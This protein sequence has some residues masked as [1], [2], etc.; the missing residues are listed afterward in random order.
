MT[1]RQPSAIGPGS[2]E[3]IAM[4]VHE[5]RT[6]L[7]ALHG[8]LAGSVADAGP[9]VRRFAAI[10]DRNASQLVTALDD[11][12]ELLRLDDT[13]LALQRDLADA[14]DLIQRAV[15][16]VQAVA[17]QLGVAII[18]EA[19]PADIAV[20]SALARNA[21]ARLLFHAARASGRGS[22][23]HVRT[24]ADATA[25][26][27]DI[28]DTGRAVDAFAAA[29]IFEPFAAAARRCRESSMRAGLDLP[30]AQAVAKLHGGTLGF[31]STNEGGQFRLVF[32]I[33]A[34][35]SLPE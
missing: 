35:R 33:D 22:V 10:A 27:I 19:Q 34:R 2:S 13:G 18:V 3:F 14:V 7:T 20:D 5:L 4:L 28:S 32:P 31:S 1:T 30:I 29:H 21:L 17:D 11:V 25:V 9:D 12:A 23:V 15:G 8:S 16:D 6:P 24:S 26:T